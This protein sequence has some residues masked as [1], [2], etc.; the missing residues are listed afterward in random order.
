M[1]SFLKRI[2]PFVRTKNADS[3]TN[4]FLDRTN[5]LSLS[6][7]EILGAIAGARRIYHKPTEEPLQLDQSDFNYNI[8]EKIDE[9]VRAKEVDGYVARVL[10][11]FREKAVKTGF[12]FEGEKEENVLKVK[13]HLENI[14]INSGSSTEA[15]IQECFNNYSSFGNLFIHKSINPVDEKIE[16]LTIMPSRGWTPTKSLGV[17][18]IKW[19][20]D[21]GAENTF[22]YTYKNIFHLHYEKETHHVF[23]VPVV[24]TALDDA[25]ILRELESANYQDYLDSL[26]KKVIYKVGDV[27]NKASQ[28]ELDEFT[29]RMNS[30]GPN[31]DIV[32]SGHITAELFRPEYNKEGQNVVSATKERVLSSL[33][34]S[35]T[36]V[37]EMGAGRQDAD[38]LDSQDDV[39][40]EDLQSS[41]E[42]QLNL[43]VIRQLCFDLFG[44]VNYDTQVKIRFNPTFTTKE[45]VEKHEIFKFLSSVS[46]IEETRA[47]LGETEKFDEKKLY[48][49]LFAKVGTTQ[50]QASVKTNPTNQHGQKGNSKAS[51]K[52]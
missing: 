24:S 17:K 6:K 27:N 40:V 36:S 46:T 39:V 42:N 48:A 4:I 28:D 12:Y 26:D 44:E 18:V 16:Y 20:Y 49:N 35:G 32:F 22:E 13:K 15:F 8:D 47:R 33:R 25:A 45:R 37:G 10:A 51:V 41:L 43:T 9:I 23:G 5:K 7:E 11:N 52:N 38:T 21:A 19:E 50:E 30:V 29:A 31:E 1:K 2:F 34:S 3:D 14:L